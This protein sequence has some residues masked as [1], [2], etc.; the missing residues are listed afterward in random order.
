MSVIDIC[1]YLIY[2]VFIHLFINSLIISIKGSLMV[3]HRS[4]YIK[5][6]KKDTRTINKIIYLYAGKHRYLSYIIMT[7]KINVIKREKS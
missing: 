2:L 6:N 3:V 4:S 1:V 5:R 7:N